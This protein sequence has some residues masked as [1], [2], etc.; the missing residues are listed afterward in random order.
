MR[1]SG[2]SSG[3]SSGVPFGS[4]AGGSAA[5]LLRLPDINFR[6]SKVSTCRQVALSTTS[7]LSLL[8]FVMS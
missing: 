2:A 1:L 8:S 5:L 4:G 7:M 6:E 3:A